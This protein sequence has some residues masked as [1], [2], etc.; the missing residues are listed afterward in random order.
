MGYK[1]LVI[2]I[3]SP[4]PSKKSSSCYIGV[5][6]LHLRSDSASIESTC[7][8]CLRLRIPSCRIQGLGGFKVPRNLGCGL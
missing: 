5:E 1:G 2:N 7:V 6:N 8:V 4:R 3:L